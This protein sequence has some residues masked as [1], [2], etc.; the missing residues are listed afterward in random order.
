MGQEKTTHTCTR[1]PTFFQQSHTQGIVSNMPQKFHPSHNWLCE[2]NHLGTG[3]TSRC[4]PSLFW[5]FCKTKNQKKEGPTLSF[6]HRY[7][8]KHAFRK[9]PKAQCAFKILMIHEVLQFALR[10][11]F[12]CVLHRCGNLD[13]HR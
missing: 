3:I 9:I 6:V 5:P 10:I 11:A 1:I 2:N 4:P 12:R 13:I 7:S 8:D